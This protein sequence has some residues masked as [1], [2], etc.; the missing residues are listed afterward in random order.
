LLRPQKLAQLGPA[1][2]EIDLSTGHAVAPTGR[3]LGRR[4]ARRC[5]GTRVKKSR[6]NIPKSCSCSFNP[7][8]RSLTYGLFMPLGSATRD[9]PPHGLARIYMVFSQHLCLAVVKGWHQIITRYITVTRSLSC[10]LLRPASRSPHTGGEPTQDT[11][12]M[13]LLAAATQAASLLI[14]LRRWLDE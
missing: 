3:S 10:G 8:R 6:S 5:V 4:S 13:R 12:K 11:R 2:G 14:I 7:W 9:M 1:P